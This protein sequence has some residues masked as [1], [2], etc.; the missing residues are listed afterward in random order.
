MSIECLF[1]LDKSLDCK[2]GAISHFGLIKVPRGSNLEMPA[3]YIMNSIQIILFNCK[4]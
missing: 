4:N 2:Q 1:R 3:K